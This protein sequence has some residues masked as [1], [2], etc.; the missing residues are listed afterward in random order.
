MQ[1]S[2][3]RYALLCFAKYDNVNNK[4]TVTFWFVVWKQI[5]IKVVVVI[6][7]RQSGLVLEQEVGV[8]RQVGVGQSARWAFLCAAKELYYAGAASSWRMLPWLE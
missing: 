3:Y 5:A 2:I 1:S 6:V 4:C 7:G 8:R